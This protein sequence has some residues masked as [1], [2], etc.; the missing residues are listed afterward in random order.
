MN[1]VM[2]YIYLKTE[3]FKKT[4]KNT[5]THTNTHINKKTN[6]NYNMERKKVSSKTNKNL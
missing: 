3:S 2:K 6:R 4:N 1:R 5:L